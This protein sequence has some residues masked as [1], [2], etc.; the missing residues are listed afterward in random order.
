MRSVSIEERVN[1]KSHLVAK[2]LSDGFLHTRGSRLGEPA[3]LRKHFRSAESPGSGPC[4][5]VA[6]AGIPQPKD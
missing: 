6:S 5:P 3:L 4:V 2:I 1:L